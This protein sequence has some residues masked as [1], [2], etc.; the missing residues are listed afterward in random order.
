MEKHPLHLKNPELQTSPEVNR[1]VKRN[2]ERT[3]EKIP[4]ETATGKFNF[5]WKKFNKDGVQD[6]TFVKT[7]Q[8]LTVTASDIKIKSTFV[9]EIALK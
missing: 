5:T 4:N 3:G 8:V 2:E 1:A 6:T 7:G 9:V